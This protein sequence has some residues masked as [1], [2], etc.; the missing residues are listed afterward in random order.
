[1]RLII[2]MIKVQIKNTNNDVYESDRVILTVPVTIL[3]NNYIDF[4][5]AFS[6]E[7]NKML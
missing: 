7:T 4:I 3:Q 2:Q 5:P 1:M 6:S